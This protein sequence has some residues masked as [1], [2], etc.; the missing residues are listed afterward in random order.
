MDDWLLNIEYK[1]FPLNY[2]HTVV[3]GDIETVHCD[4][5][6]VIDIVIEVLMSQGSC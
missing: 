6:V 5:Y 3:V 1:L 2:P 4:D